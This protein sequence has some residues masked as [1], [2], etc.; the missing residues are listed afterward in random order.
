MTLAYNYIM[1]YLPTRYVATAKQEHERRLVYAFKKG[2][3]DHSVKEKFADAVKEI[4]GNDKNNWVVLFIPA[5][6]EYKTIQRFASLASFIERETG[7]KATIDGIVAREETESQCL[8]GTRFDKTSFY[9]FDTS[10]YRGKNVILI[11]DVITSGRSFKSCAI[12]LKNSGA[13]NVRGLFLAKTINPDWI[14]S[15]A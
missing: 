6:S 11:D 2:N 10:L 13:N 14:H 12:K 15:V 9:N 8:T 7:V 1:E 4:V 3:Y 5:S